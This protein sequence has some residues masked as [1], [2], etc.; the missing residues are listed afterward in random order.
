[1]NRW[2]IGGAATVAV[3]LV[4][5]FLVFNPFSPSISE[6][7]SAEMDAPATCREAGYKEVAGEREKVWNC[8][9]RE[10]HAPR[11]VSSSNSK[12]VRSTYRSVCVALIDGD[13]VGAGLET[14]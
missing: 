5:L 8:T 1:M 7:V 11:V 6:R 3:A 14:C 12:R 9:Y 10:D 13:V 4:A 2:V